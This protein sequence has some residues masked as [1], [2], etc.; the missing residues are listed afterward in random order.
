MTKAN[1]FQT[2]RIGKSQVETVEKEMQEDK[3]M[4]QL[5]RQMIR[6]TQNEVLIRNNEIVMTPEELL[7]LY[8]KVQQ[9][10]TTS[11]LKA[12]KQMSKT[13]QKITNIDKQHIIIR[14]LDLFY[15]NNGGIDCDT[16]TANI[17][18]QKL[19]KTEAFIA[20]K[21]K[22]KDEREKFFK[23]RHDA[24][25]KMFN[26]RQKKQE[27]QEKAVIKEEINEWNYYETK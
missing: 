13:K 26:E 10:Q 19:G 15:L 18:K 5:Y 11:L 23:E 8:D 22:H 6:N 2:L 27:A 4:L 20:I 24:I 14:L 16:I 1:C 9:I 17:K 3:L 25:Q 7:P 12:M 21:K